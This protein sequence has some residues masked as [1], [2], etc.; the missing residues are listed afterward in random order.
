MISLDYGSQCS[1]YM[2]SWRIMAMQWTL[3]L[4]NF[5]IY[6]KSKYMADLWAASEK[7]YISGLMVGGYYWLDVLK[8]KWCILHQVLAMLLLRF[9]DPISNG[10]QTAY[11]GLNVQKEK[12]LGYSLWIDIVR[13]FY[14]LRYHS[15]EKLVIKDYFS[16]TKIT[17]HKKITRQ[18]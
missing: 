4:L 1:A 5:C 8:W 17:K 7:Y 12:I 11:S 13:A 9:D 10:V 18:W 15:F 6:Q 2:H 3:V 14:I 16:E